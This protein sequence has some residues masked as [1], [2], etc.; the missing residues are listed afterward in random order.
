MKNKFLNIAF[1][2]LVLILLVVV[3]YLYKENK[4][5]GVIDLIKVK[6]EYKLKLELE[7]KAKK[8]L[9]KYATVLDSLNNIIKNSNNEVTKKRISAEFN[10]VKEK[11]DEAIIESNQ[12]I[13]EKIWERI[14]PIVKEFGDENG[15]DIIMG[16]S[17]NGNVLFV[18]DKKQINISDKFI[19]Y[20]NDKYEGL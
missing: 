8:G 14:N 15:Y 20:L 4:K 17:G 6:N 13:D 11:A 16:A 18:Q 2:I 5:I 7:E 12:V 19:K 9:E 3:F 1:F 10:F